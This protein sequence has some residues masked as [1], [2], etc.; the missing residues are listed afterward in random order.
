MNMYICIFI[1]YMYMYIYV[2]VQAEIHDTVVC[3]Y[4]SLLL[5]TNSSGIQ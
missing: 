2:F 3:L 4:V 5:C 1:C